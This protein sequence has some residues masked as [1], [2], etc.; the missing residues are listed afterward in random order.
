MVA[1]E[2]QLRYVV[3]WQLGYY[4]IHANSDQSELSQTNRC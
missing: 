1:Y 3:T 4:Y 2:I